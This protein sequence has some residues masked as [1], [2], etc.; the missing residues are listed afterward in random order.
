MTDQ[1]TERD[2]FD[3]RQGVMVLAAMNRLE[4]LDPALLRAGHFERQMVVGQPDLQSR[5]VCDT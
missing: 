3:P 5:W 1:L 4:I 2:G